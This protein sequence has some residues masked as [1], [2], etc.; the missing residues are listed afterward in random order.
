M[1]ICSSSQALCSD[2][3]APTLNSFFV[4]SCTFTECGL[5]L[6]ASVRLPTL[7]GASVL[8]S[9]VWGYRVPLLD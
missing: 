7:S 3:S 6:R 9:C 1:E 5:R 4:G 8:A 2:C